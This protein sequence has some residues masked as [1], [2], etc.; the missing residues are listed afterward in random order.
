MITENNNYKYLKYNDFW[1]NSLQRIESI[2]KDIEKELNTL[3]K[4]YFNFESV[5]SEIIRRVGILASIYSS[6]NNLKGGEYIL[7]LK[8]ILNNYKKRYS[9][10]GIDFKAIYFLNS[11]INKLRESSFNNFPQMKHSHYVKFDSFIETGDTIDST[12]ERYNTLKASAKYKWIS[13]KRNGSWFLTP[14]QK[15]IIVNPG[16]AKIVTADSK[17]KIDFENQ[18]ID[19]TDIFSELVKGKEEPANYYIIIKANN[20]LS[21]HAAYKLGRVVMSDK[22]FISPFL[23]ALKKNKISPGRFRIFGKNHLY[24]DFP[25]NNF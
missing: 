9:H 6:H 24:L 25:A 18:Q 20:V 19:I 5:Y 8:A 1:Q 17:K 13:Y 22:N 11:K 15:F 16:D 4:K 12:I 2:T 14:Y 7:K 21:C 23:K 10:G 3:E